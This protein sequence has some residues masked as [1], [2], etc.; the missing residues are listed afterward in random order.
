MDKQS[1]STELSAFAAAQ[2]L[3]EPPRD[4]ADLD[5]EATW[6]CR[7]IGGALISWYNH[8]YPMILDERAALRVRGFDPEPILVITT[9]LAGLTAVEMLFAEHPDPPIALPL[10]AFES[11]LQGHPPDSFTFHVQHLNAFE[12]PEPRLQARIEELAPE[13]EPSEARVHVEGDLWGELCGMRGRHLW[14]WDPAAGEATLLQE[15]F[16]RELS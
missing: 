12:A 7:T 11:W 14:R 1:W 13:L 9:E 16:E 8:R 3:A 15:A 6:R 5:P 10:D 4:L 2:R